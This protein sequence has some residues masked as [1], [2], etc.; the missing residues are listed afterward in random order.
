MMQVNDNV[1]HVESIDCNI[2]SENGIDV[3]ID[4]GYFSQS[5]LAFVLLIFVKVLLT[6]VLDSMV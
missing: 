1:Q 2:I 5:V 3:D 6:T 4:N